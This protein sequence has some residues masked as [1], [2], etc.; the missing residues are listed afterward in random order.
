[1]GRAGR[2]RGIRLHTS[3][4]TATRPRYACWGRARNPACHG[5][6]PRT[7]RL[8][9]NLHPYRHTRQRLDAFS[10][11]ATIRSGPP[12]RSWRRRSCATGRR[13]GAHR[14]NL[15]S[16]GGRTG[17]GSINPAVTPAPARPRRRSRSDRRREEAIPPTPRC[18]ASGVVEFTATATGGGGTGPRCGHSS[19]APPIPSSIQALSGTA[20]ITV[21]VRESSNASVP[22]A[23]VRPHEPA[24]SGNTSRSQ[25]ALTGPMESPPERWRRPCRVPGH[26]R[27]S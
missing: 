19:V 26:S 8:S 25:G 21:T 10:F 15:G 2:Q 20:T 22:G 24:E 16:L 13:P 17:G 23:T 18:R 9:R 14:R 4:P 1:M 12:G 27:D 5:V 6:G 11:P 3:E 7:R